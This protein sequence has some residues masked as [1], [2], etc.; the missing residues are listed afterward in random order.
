MIKN[1]IFDFDGVLVESLGIKTDAFNELFKDFPDKVDEIVKFH[2]DNGGMSRFD[3]FRY[4]YKNIFKQPLSEVKFNKLCRDFSNLVVEKVVVAPFVKGAIEFLQKG[5]V[6]YNMYV[7]SATPEEELKSII[8]KRK[9]NKYFLGIYGS[10]GNKESLLLKILQEN[11]Y[12]QAE[13]IFLGDSINDYLAAQKV[14]VKF[15]ARISNGEKTWD[16]VRVKMKLKDLFEFAKYIEE[17]SEVKRSCLGINLKV[18]K[19]K[20]I[21][22][23]IVLSLSHIFLRKKFYEYNFYAG[24]TNF[25]EVMSIIKA[26]LKGEPLQDGRYISAYEKAF[27]DYLGVKFSW[28]FA[29]GRMGLYAIL[30]ALNIQ[31]GDEI[32]V[33]AYTCVVVINSIIYSGGKPVYVDIDAKTFNIDV[34]KIEEKVTPKTRALYAQHTFGLMCNI[35]AIQRTASK[36]NLPIIEDCCLAL[37]SEIKARK[38][39]TL[40]TIAYFSTD[41]SKV[42]STSSGGMVVTNDDVLAKR[43]NQLYCQAPFCSKKLILRML[44]TFVIEDMLRR[45]SIYF[46]GKYLLSFFN[47]IGF[48]F[49]FTDY[50]CL[51]RPRDYPFPARLSN[52]QAMLGLNQLG[53]L[54]AI[55][56]HHKKVA[57]KYD[58]RLSVYSNYF[59]KNSREHIF[60]RYVFLVENPS[61][62]KKTTEKYLEIES[63]FSSIAQCRQDNFQEIY[64][65]EGTC[66]TA[67]WVS[68]R[69]INL[70]THFKI[71]NPERI[72]NIL[73]KL[74]KTKALDYRIIK[75]ENAQS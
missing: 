5:L 20:K 23:Y 32:I 13:T 10:P 49:F 15:A 61:A 48:T 54:E 26:I 42:I 53:L 70:P 46:W 9:I 28:S 64:Y 72:V 51:S 27:R 45:Q 41:H 25:K 18:K 67:E 68:K 22:S 60:L 65:T 6:R 35:E 58:E 69:V 8:I 24:T 21:A 66:P 40:G 37:G 4:I 50:Y 19:A 44:F 73:E 7:V 2:L 55:I 34:T 36:Y 3:K 71:K 31:K 16:L 75:D 59:R 14:K 56:Q 62:W 38:A 33:P 39:G 47:R 57:E 1:I 12:C 11:N 43:I 17:A 74:L 29:T 52:L 63:W 30:K